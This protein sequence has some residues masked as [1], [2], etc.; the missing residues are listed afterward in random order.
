MQIF[1]KIIVASSV[2]LFASLQTQTLS[3]Q[4][5]SVKMTNPLLQKSKLQYQAP[6]FDLIKDEYYKPAFEYGLK[7]HDQEIDKIANNPA[8]PTFQNTVLAL[9]LSG[10][11]LN[12]AMRIFSNLA[13]SNTN[14]TLQ[15][16]EAEYAPIFS[17]H[18]DKMYLNSKLYKRFKALNL[19]TLKGEDKRL[20]EYYLQQFELAG[21]NLSPGDKAKMKKINEELATLGTQF[22]SKL[23]TARKNGAVIFDNV[24]DLDGL[25]SEEIAAAKTKATE[26][27]QEGKYLIPLLNTTQQPLLASLKNR[28]TREKIFKASWY[29]AEK[30]DDGD[31]RETL[32]KTAK[33]RLQKAKLMGKKSFAEWKLQDQMAKTPAPAMDLLAKIAAPAVAKAKVEAK[34][35]QDLIDSQKGGFKLEPWDWDFYSEQVRKAKYDLDQ[36]Q[37]KPYFELTSVLEKGVFFAAKQMYGITFK[38]RNDLPVYHPDVKVYEVFDKDGVSISI[39]YLDFYTRDNKKGGAWMDNFV[40]QTHYL[41]QKPVIVNV[42]NFSKP[43]NGNPSLISSDDVKTMFHEFGHTLHGLFA[44]Q[45]YASISGTSVPRDFVE[46]PSQINEHAAL[47][48]VVLS[49]YAVHY[50]TKQPIPQELVEKIK[51]AET[52]NKG[53]EVTEILAAS[54]VDMAWHSVENEAD[55]KPTLEFEK[56]ALQKYGLLVSEVPPRYHSTYFQHIWGGDGYSAGYYAYTWSKTLDYNVYD[57]MMANGG[58]TKANCDRFRKYILS[59]GNSVD[60]N[61]AFKE[62]IGHDMQ[63]EPYLKN[64]GLTG[65]E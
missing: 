35:I 33:L 3:A 20:T 7:T 1:S 8:K 30:G 54:T 27:G 39:Y 19:K 16:I 29:R 34:E 59:V 43:A 9:E 58:M 60:L 63:I 64:A 24:K 65:K 18:S 41:K 12:R 37:I 23:L 51:K 36:S 53:Y 55:F 45:Q 52:F 32:E 57:W 11:D 21:A 47:D 61:K 10:V 38:E 2:F 56:E 15:A 22:N 25:S 42:Y 13:V 17:A 62:F 50:Q 44:N 31:T 14:P 6:P 4:N 26:A 40:N 49:N 28:A 46:F 48:P 5:N